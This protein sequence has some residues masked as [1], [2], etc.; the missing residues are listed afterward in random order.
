VE[1]GFDLAGAA[2]IQSLLTFLYRDA[3]LAVL[4]E[5]TANAW[6]SHV[7][8]GTSAPV[9]VHLPT[10]WDP[11]LTVADRGVGLDEQEIVQVY[12]PYGL[13][14]KRDS[15]DEIGAYGIGAKA[16]FTIAS[17]FTV[18]GVKDGKKVTALFA[19][20]ESGTATV[21]IIGRDATDAPDGVTVAV[22]VRDVPG[23]R[24][25]AETLFA[26]WPRGTIL[27]DGEQP[28]YL[29]DSMLAV[30]DR[31]FADR[32]GEQVH[33]HYAHSVREDSPTG[34]T[35]VMGGV[36]YRANVAMLSA[37]VRRVPS[38]HRAV[39]QLAAELAAKTTQVRL[40]Y[41]ADIGEVD[42][43]PSREDL[44]D[45][46][47]TLDALEEMLAVFVDSKQRA[48]EAVL[49]AEPSRMHASN[50]LVE[51]STFLPAGLMSQGQ[52][53]WRGHLLAGQIG[54]PYSVITRHTTDLSSRCTLHEGYTVTLGTDFS[55]T[56][57]V[58]GVDAER[59]RKVRR[60]ANRFMTHHDLDMLVLVPGDTAAVGWFAADPADSAAAIRPVTFDQF[61]TE[62]R[63]LPTVS[64]PRGETTYA[65]WRE[66]FSHVTAPWT[67]TRITEHAETHGGRV[68]LE[69][70]G[71]WPDAHL[72]INDV[73]QSG[74]VVVRLTRSQTPEA[75]FRRFP[76]AHRLQ[77]LVAEHAKTL[78]GQASDVERLALRHCADPVMEAV[79]GERRLREID[80]LRQLVADYTAAARAHAAVNTR[81]LSLL[82]AAQRVLGRPPARPVTDTGLPLLDL[83]V[84]TLRA[85]SR[86]PQKPVDLATDLAA[87]LAAY[88]TLH[89]NNTAT[90]AAVS[91]G[92][93]T[94]KRSA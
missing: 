88:L 59:E 33:Y 30:T 85:E 89:P 84:A 3:G 53:R 12:A 22:P 58:C 4:R 29:P 66:Q 87:D 69:T 26:F 18:A 51:L 2:H 76:D 90:S 7:R 36:P 37:V 64:A 38:E 17:Q 61:H 65:V 28:E 74:D 25:A 79:R 56:W 41:L 14:T 13:S 45:T 72:V 11:V 62:A 93:V 63:G 91:T 32:H 67:V 47:R 34:V 27:V 68:L 9:E 57:V 44:R 16:A 46:P 19:L 71:L 49:D 92:T 21:E 24:R 5:Y 10:E 77:D 55:R 42:I 23:M 15:D 54:L 20:N 81:R 86:S 43:T 8:A 82:A 70:S 6:D 94:T 39:R 83:V 35:I 73:V 80:P 78:L 50:R 48:V 40:V 75:F 60:L 1:C 52:V 31:L